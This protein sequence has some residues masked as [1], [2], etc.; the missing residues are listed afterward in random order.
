MEQCQ[1]GVR[2]LVRRRFSGGGSSS[3]AEA[4]AK[5]GS[6]GGGSAEVL[7]GATAAKPWGSMVGEETV[8]I[9]SASV[10]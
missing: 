8:E 7:I 2:R 1:A 6:F 5:A 4:L 3:E 10:G 9:E